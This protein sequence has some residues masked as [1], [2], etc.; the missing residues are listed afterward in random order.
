MYIG[1]DVGTSGVKAELIRKD[2]SVLNS[3]QVSYGFSNLAGGYRELDARK[4]WDAVCVC[5]KKAGAGQPVRSITVSS[6]GEAII[7]VDVSGEALCPSIT[8]TDVRG[9]KEAEECRLSVSD[10]G[11]AEIT[12]LNFSTIYSGYKILWLKRH[13]REL[14]EKAWKIFTFQDYVIF[15]LSGV[16]VVDYSMA[17]RTMLFDINTK[18]WSE[19]LLKI[20][21]IGRELL[22]TPVQGGSIAGEITAQEAGRL[23]L[24]ASVKIVAGTHDHICNAIGC[25]TN[26]EGQCT[27]TVGTSEGLTALI[28]RSALDAAAVGRWQMACEPFVIKD[29]YNTVAWNNTSGA[30]LRW[31]VQKLLGKAAAPDDYEVLDQ[32]MQEEPTELMVLPHFSGAATPHMDNRSRGAILGLTL[33]TDK[34]DIYKSLMEGANY[35]LALILDCLKRSGQ[36]ITR[37]CATGGAASPC[38]LQIKADV[39]GME[40]HTVTNKQTGTLGGAILGA[41]ALS[42]YG[43]IYEAA[44]AMVTPGRTYMPDERKHRIYQERLSLYRELYQATA[45]IHHRLCGV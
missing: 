25:G 1:L 7:P 45:S 21:G 16:T 34:L 32:Q 44:D 31:Y 35:E 4:V 17:S 3:C 40:V 26:Q 42:D 14:Y 38:L 10:I 33:D 5:L 8:G 28:K 24:P 9:S 12:G 23:G 41:V 39:L 11:L 20:T 19:K 22:S 43:D 18:D 13:Q 37:L 36:K 6:L 30:M 15:K 2:G 29:T 27:N